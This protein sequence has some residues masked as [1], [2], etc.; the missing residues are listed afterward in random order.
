[1]GG[2]PGGPF[3]SSI[4]RHKVLKLAGHVSIVFGF[5]LEA[6]VAYDWYVHMTSHLIVAVLGGFAILVGTQLHIFAAMA[7]MLI[8]LYRELDARI[9]ETP[10]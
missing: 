8:T 10:E 7:S 9:G 3:Q 5:L 6:W 4:D 1:M 2:Y